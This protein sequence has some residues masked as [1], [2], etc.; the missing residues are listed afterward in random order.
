MDDFLNVLKKDPQVRIKLN[1]ML[2]RYIRLTNNY[3]S[4]IGY[5]TL[6]P[7]VY[8][9]ESVIT[10]RTTITGLDI[11]L[12]TK[13]SWIKYLESE[14]SYNWKYRNSIMIVCITNDGY[15]QDAI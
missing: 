9:K 13:I 8:L 10:M 15:L 1:D 5:D 12:I 6:I 14:Y 4:K 7:N 11:E 3:Q 2:D